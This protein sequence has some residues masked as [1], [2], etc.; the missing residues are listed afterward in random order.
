MNAAVCHQHNLV[1]NALSDWQPVQH[2]TKYRSDVLVE[3]SASDEARSSVQYHLQM[4]NSV[5]TPGYTALQY[6]TLLVISA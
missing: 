4:P 1:L 3:S 5:Y 2:D 6:S